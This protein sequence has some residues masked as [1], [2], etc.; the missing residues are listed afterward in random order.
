N[1]KAAPPRPSIGGNTSISLE[2]TPAPS[3]I[4]ATQEAASAE[5]TAAKAAVSSERSNP[6]ATLSVDSSS[7][8]TPAAQSG[9]TMTLNL[10]ATPAPIAAGRTMSLTE[11]AEALEN[12]PAAILVHSL[13]ALTVRDRDV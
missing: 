2:S 6:P 7:Q 5:A 13:T 4:A 8:P 10:A 9:D 3:P 11:V 1:A 12:N